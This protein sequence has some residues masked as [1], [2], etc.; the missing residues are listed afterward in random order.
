VDAHPFDARAL[1]RGTEEDVEGA[2]AA[3]GDRQTQRRPPGVLDPP[4]QRRG[5]R[6]GGE[7]ALEGVGSAER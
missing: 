7:G 2:V 1:S 4:G 5:G 6:D 3:V